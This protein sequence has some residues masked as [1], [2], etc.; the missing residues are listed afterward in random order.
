MKDAE[1]EAVAVVDVAA[2]EKPE[3]AKREGEAAAAAAAPLFP[4][5]SAMDTNEG[6]KEK[7]KITVP[8][9]K[10]GALKQQWVEI[11]TPLVSSLKLQVR[12]NTKTRQVE[13]QTSPHTE[14]A[15]AIQ[16]GADF[17]RAF[18]LGFEVK[19]AVAL[20]RLDDLYI[21]SFEIEDVRRLAGDHLSRA[22]GRIAGRDGRTKILIENSTRTRIVLA[23]KRIHILGSFANIKVAKD[24]LVDLILGSP[25]GKVHA[26]LR[27]KAA[28]LNERW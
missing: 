12:M 11:F 22:I 24:A 14:D 25:P 20:L 10:M 2:V 7:R 18:L 15:G 19:D 13:L 8:T 9:H 27:A 3:E 6:N 4:P 21:D 26:S 1:E 5:A 17:V 23:D 28:R 16:R